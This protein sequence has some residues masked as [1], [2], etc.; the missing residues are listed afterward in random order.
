MAGK[1]ARTNKQPFAIARQA[2]RDYKLGRTIR[3]Y[4]K[5]P[6][7]AGH[8]GNGAKESQLEKVPEY[9]LRSSTALPVTLSPTTE[10]PTPH[11]LTPGHLPQPSTQ[12]PK[13]SPR[14]GWQFNPA[15]EFPWRFQQ[16]VYAESNWRGTWILQVKDLQGMDWGIERV[17]NENGRGGR[18][19][20]RPTRQLPFLPGAREQYAGEVLGDG[21]QDDLMFWLGRP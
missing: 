20:R 14:E 6:E 2:W 19:R 17:P 15:D 18:Y 11:K 7:E 3:K 13:S 8:Q 10:F 5:E 21:G 12:P 4:R 16:V 9:S 1:I